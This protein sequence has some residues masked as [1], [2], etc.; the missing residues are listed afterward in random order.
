MS[1]Y[2]NQFI[3]IPK[4]SE[5]YRVYMCLCPNW[6]ALR[7]AF[8]FLF[9]VRVSQQMIEGITSNRWLST[10]VWAVLGMVFQIVETTQ[11]ELLHHHR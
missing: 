11:M 6:L 5:T 4:I 7:S 2:V 8:M 3:H 1:T 10:L 9:G